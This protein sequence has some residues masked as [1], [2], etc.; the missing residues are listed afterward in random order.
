MYTF[1]PHTHT[2]YGHISTHTYMHSLMSV[3]GKATAK[4][5]INFCNMQG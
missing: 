3:I 5:R 2:H 1:N 4:E